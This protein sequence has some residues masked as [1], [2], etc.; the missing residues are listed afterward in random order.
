[1]K[2]SE[3]RRLIR[4]CI[5][6]INI[7]LPSSKL[8]F[9][10]SLYELTFDEIIPE[11]DNISEEEQMWLENTLGTSDN[12]KMFTPE[13]FVKVHAKWFN[14]LFPFESGDSE[15]LEMEL[16]ANIYKYKKIPIQTAIETMKLYWEMDDEEWEYEEFEDRYR[17]TFSNPDGG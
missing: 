8:R 2:Q 5:N 13:E 6:E 14:M 10:E 9:S 12:P 1:M 4:E 11:D 15:S 3:L 16:H 7:E 17:D